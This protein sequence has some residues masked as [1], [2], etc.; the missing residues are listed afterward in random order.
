MLAGIESSSDEEQHAEQMLEVAEAAADAV[1][2][3]AGEHSDSGSRLSELARRLLTPAS[4]SAAAS[5]C[6]S[7]ERAAPAQGRQAPS[8]LQLAPSTSDIAVSSRFGPTV[9]SPGAMS[10]GWQRPSALGAD[11]I[12]TI[13]LPVDE[14]SDE[15]D[16]ELD[17]RLMHKYGIRL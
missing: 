17:E 7:R 11:V 6:S 13:R 15:S 12:R 4:P 3:Q 14:E 16:S 9:V 8:Q 2:Q 5:A 10:A 1:A